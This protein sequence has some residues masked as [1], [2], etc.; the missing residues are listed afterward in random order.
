MGAV[1]GAVSAH[2]A[3]S[4]LKEHKPAPFHERLGRCHRAVPKREINFA[5]PRRAFQRGWFQKGRLY[6]NGA[7]AAASPAPAS[8][9]ATA[10]SAPRPRSTR[11]SVPRVYKLSPR[12]RFRLIPTR[13]KV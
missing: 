7:C 5:E 2:A 4:G 13:V 10:T 8:G 3:A 12:L 6:W 9:S 1:Q 11:I